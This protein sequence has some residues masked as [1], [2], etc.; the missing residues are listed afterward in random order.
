[1]AVLYEIYADIRHWHFESLARCGIPST[2]AF[3]LERT[4]Q[5]G[6]TMSKIFP[7]FLGEFSIYWCIVPFSSK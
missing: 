7:F 4:L 3:L 1:M 5:V 2:N 6:I